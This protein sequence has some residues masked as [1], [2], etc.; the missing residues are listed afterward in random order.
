MGTPGFNFDALM[1][2]MEPAFASPPG[3]LSGGH[4][5]QSWGTVCQ[6]QRRIEINDR[7]SHCGSC[8][9]CGAQKLESSDAFCHH[10][11]T[12]HIEIIVPQTKPVQ[13]LPQLSKLTPLF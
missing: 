11:G 2:A 9:S 13:L 1:H 7:A 3:M 8:T 12:K 5:P 10:C 4:M 6:S